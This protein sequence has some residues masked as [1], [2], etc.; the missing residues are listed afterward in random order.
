MAFRPTATLLAGAAFLAQSLALAFADPAPRSHPDAVPAGTIT[1]RISPDANGA[2]ATALHFAPHGA[3]LAPAILPRTRPQPPA[4][5]VGDK[6]PIRSDR[7]ASLEAFCPII[8]SEAKRNGLPPAFFARLIWTES[9]FNASALSPK[10]AQGIAQFM[11]GT[12]AE[13]GL[14]D[15][16]NPAEAIPHS[17]L[18]LKE[19]RETFGNVGLAAAAYNAGPDRVAKWLSGASTL[20]GETEDFVYAITG[21]TARD[22]SKGDH[23]AIGLTA[24]QATAVQAGC[25]RLGALVAKL[26]SAPRPAVRQPWGVQLAADFSQAKALAIYSRVHAHFGAVLPKGEP[27]IVHSRNLS[28]G[29]KPVHAVRIGAP[30]RHGAQEICDR[31]RAAGGVCVVVRN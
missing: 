5:S 8:E 6:P 26:P 10:G 19:L 23:H 27:M 31:L 28:R 12:A 3:L 11:P 13:R 9:R 2:D 18:Y 7:E 20:P 21:T 25:R 22:W 24:E 29:A 16:F 30:S 4:D 14:L 17:A 1:T 15:P